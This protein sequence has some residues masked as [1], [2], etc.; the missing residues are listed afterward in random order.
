MSQVAI[1]KAFQDWKA[2][3]AIDNTPVT[4]DEFVFAFIPG[5]DIT[6]PIDVAETLPAADKIVYRQEVS[7]AGIINDNA[8]SYS[9]TVG[10]EIGDFDFNWIGLVNSES[11]VLA[12]V[13]HVP[14]QRKIKNA[15]GQQ[16]NVL[17]RSMMM[18]YT[19][20]AAATEI[21]TPAETWQIDFT[22]RLAGIDER[23]RL[24]NVDLYADAAFFGDG[25]LVAR[26]GEQYFV[27]QGAGYVA[28]L[29]ADLPENVNIEVSGPAK[30]WLDVCWSGTLTSVW[31]VQCKITIADELAN[32]QQNG[33]SHYVCAV[34]SI[35]ENGNVTDLRPKGLNE[36]LG[37]GEL[38]TLGI[39]DVLPVGVPQPWPTNIPPPK[40]G[41]MQGQ[42]FDP[43][44]YPLLAAA[45]PSGIL[46]DMRSRTI[47]GNPESGRDVLSYEDDGNKAHAHTGTVAATDLG[48]RWTTAFD[49]GAKSTEIA[50]WHAHSVEGTVGDSG[51]NWHSNWETSNN[52]D[53]MYQSTGGEGNHAHAVYIGAH[54]H[55]VEIGAHTHGVIIN[56]DGNA[57]T[58]VKNISFN[59][60]VRLA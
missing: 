28:G 51:N 8:V 27:T 33:R 60:I 49:Y 14:T 21:T 1:T 12:M 3:Q 35:D 25:W 22:A 31:S 23:K 41:L 5:L 7:K 32:Y 30:V 20:A 16:G 24:E 38:A 29:R 37:L 39:N 47:K 4:L 50:G 59:Y 17:V 13:I 10:A 34:A 15:A 56:A 11:S 55:T 6:K 57:E 9:V 53:Y 43:V 58:T 54:S 45:Y 2:Q 36:D 19:G 40:W 44:A 46:P 48:T 18:E 52:D 42:T 26:Q